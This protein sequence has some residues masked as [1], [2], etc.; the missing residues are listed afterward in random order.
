M[1]ISSSE[2][3]M[4]CLKCVRA[5]RWGESWG[6]WALSMMCGCTVSV[7]SS[8]R[9]GWARDG[10]GHREQRLAEQAIRDRRSGLSS[11]TSNRVAS[12]QWLNVTESSEWN[13]WYL[14][15]KI[16]RNKWYLSN[17]PDTYESLVIT[18][19]RPLMGDYYLYLWSIWLSSNM[20]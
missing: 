6:A 1:F 12:D 2:S 14:F 11:V 8:P 18:I 20:T 19:S 5:E 7:T 17:T 3:G 16:V 13:Y 15:R 10:E 4:L 9:W